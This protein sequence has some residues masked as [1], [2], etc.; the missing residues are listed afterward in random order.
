MTRVKFLL[1]DKWDYGKTIM[2]IV[3]MVSS[4]FRLAANARKPRNR[5]RQRQYRTPSR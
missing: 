4:V 3:L 1:I 5:C 2:A